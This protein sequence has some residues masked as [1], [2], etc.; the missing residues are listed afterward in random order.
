MSG[1]VA[2]SRKKAPGK[3][4]GPAQTHRAVRGNAGTEASFPVGSSPTDL[5]GGYLEVLEDI[6][7]RICE[8]R[9][10]IALSANSAMV[11]LY[12]DV[13]R[14]ILARQEDEGWGARVVDRLSE[15]LRAAYPD[16]KGLSP[17]N[18][19]YM[20]A[21]ASAWPDR[22]IVQRVVAQLPWRQN[23]AL[24]ECLDDQGTRL[25]Y[26]EKT[27]ENGWSQ[28]ILRIQIER[29]LHLRQGQVP[30]GSGR[31]MAP[32]PRGLGRSGCNRGRQRVPVRRPAAYEHGSPGGLRLHHRRV[33]PRL[34]SPG[35]RD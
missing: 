4:V 10:R 5:P 30:A 34:G 18:L 22:E 26:A 8:A 12:W 35:Q 21:F 13:G 33:G 23:I 29:G 25:W 19:K 32:I 2:G 6:K 17:R 28:S 24:M 1:A 27:L 31:R 3:G 16:M 7:A 15:D 11:L 20:R 9:V 14:M